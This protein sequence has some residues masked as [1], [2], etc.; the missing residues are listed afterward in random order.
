[1]ELPVTGAGNASRPVASSGSI[2]RPA[3]RLQQLGMSLVIGWEDE[4]MRWFVE[5]LALALAA[6]PLS[7]SA[8]REVW[9]VPA[10]T[11]ESSL[12]PLDPSQCNARELDAYTETLAKDVLGGRRD[13]LVRIGF[14][15]RS[16]V[17]AVCV[18]ETTGRDAGR[19]RKAIAANLLELQEVPV[20]PSCVAGRRIDF[21]RYE[22]KLAETKRARNWCRIASAGRM[23]APLSCEQFAADWILYDRIGVTRPYL[24]VK[25]DGPGTAAAD[26]LSRCARAAHGFEEQARC[27]EADGFELIPPPP[28]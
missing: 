27:I 1:M 7:A 23:T 2:R 11:A 6:V 4:P 20:G 12:P 16:R 17:V 28:R 9:K 5:S 8:E 25:A 24:Y 10:C 18:D 19:A 13:D 21:N 26:T 22:A 14:D 3:R 15:E